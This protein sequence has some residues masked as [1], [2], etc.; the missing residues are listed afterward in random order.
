MTTLNNTEEV[1][2]T[3]IALSSDFTSNVANVDNCSYA[4]WVKVAW[5]SLDSGGSLQLQTAD[6]DEGS[7]CDLLTTPYTVAAG[8]GAQQFTIKTDEAAGPRFRVKYTND[9]N[10]TG[11]M[12]VKLR[13]KVLR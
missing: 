13:K 12:L 8:T 5:D 9:G 1:L 10:T 2:S 7:W 6:V 4:Y 11:T 3:Q